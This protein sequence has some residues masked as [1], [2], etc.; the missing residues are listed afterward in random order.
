[1]RIRYA[2]KAGAVVATVLAATLIPP[3]SAASAAG[4]DWLDGTYGSAAPTNA[5][6]HG[7][8]RHA[9][10]GMLATE[11]WAGEVGADLSPRG[12][13]WLARLFGKKGLT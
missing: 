3:T 13:C 7:R 11:L 6:R 12:L 2:G 5:K 10:I 8:S 1:M 4:G 9:V